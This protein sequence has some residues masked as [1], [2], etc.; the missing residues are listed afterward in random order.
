VS[1][2]PD[3]IAA[4]LA[5]VRRRIVDAG[6]DDSVRI[7]AV[8][9][10]RSPEDVRAAVTA[11][12]VDLGEN[13]AHELVGKAEACSDLSVRWHFVGRLQSNKVRSLAPH[14]ALYQSVDRPSLIDEIARRAPGAHVLVQVDLADLA[15][16]G[17]CRPEEA[18]ALV[19]AA[20][21]RDLVVDGLMGVA[22]PAGA[23]RGA[24]RAA[25][26][27]LASLGRSLDL[28]ELSMGMT[29]DLEEAVAAGATMVRVGT[30]LFGPRPGPGR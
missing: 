19:D 8:T 7:V 20:R 15:G 28:V 17:G 1:E 10:G 21:G 12:L 16:R 11:G 29:G 13:Y 2:R 26:D 4:R 30:A 27:R 18:G 5:E 6:G 9:K 3:S 24:V 23:D 22:P 14:V 25:F